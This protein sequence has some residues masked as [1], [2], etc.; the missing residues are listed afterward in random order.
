MK[1]RKRE[2]QGTI[3]RIMKTEIKKTSKQVRRKREIE[4]DKKKKKSLP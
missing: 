1:I 3:R 4:R 2:T